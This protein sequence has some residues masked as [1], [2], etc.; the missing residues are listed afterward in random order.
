MTKLL[1]VLLLLS[2]AFFAHRGPSN[3]DAITGK[4][5]NTDKN[6]EV[7]VYKAGNEY[8]GRVIWFDDTDDK[9]S[10]MNERRD[11]KN[12]DK[13]LRSRKIIGLVVMTGLVYNNDDDE[14]QDGRIYDSS[15]GKDWN[16]KA[17]I[18]D[19]GILKVRGYWHFSIF[20]ENISFNRIQ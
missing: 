6:L 14:W 7:E 2:G 11:T 5:M 3:A 16:A 4:W 20:G 15:S 10:P 17:W 12:P 9:S 1:S 19:E 18:N 13:S 8:N